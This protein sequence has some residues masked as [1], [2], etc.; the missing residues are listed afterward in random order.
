MVRGSLFGLLKSTMS[1]SRP[2]SFFV[3]SLEGR[4]LGNVETMIVGRRDI[5][6]REVNKAFAHI[7]DGALVPSLDLLETLKLWITTGSVQY[8]YPASNV[9]FFTKALLFSLM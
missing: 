5:E 1:T 8:L 6:E 2:G 7:E 3:G 9:Q 4:Y